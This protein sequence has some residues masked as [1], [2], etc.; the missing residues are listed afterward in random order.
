M[1]GLSPDECVGLTV[2]IEAGKIHYRMVGDSAARKH[3][4]AFLDD[5]EWGGLQHA[6]GNYRARIGVRK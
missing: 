3:L 5:L 4:R 6:E 2:V 1:E